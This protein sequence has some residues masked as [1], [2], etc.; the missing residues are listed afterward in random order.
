MKRIILI[1]SFILVFVFCMAGF[2][3]ESRIQE[4][5]RTAQTMEQSTEENIETEQ[6]DS[7]AGNAE[8]EQT[9]YIG[10]VPEEYFS[11]ADHAGQVIEVTYDSRDYTDDSQPAI[12]KTAYV[13]L[14]Y[15]YDEA[16]QDTRYDILY[17]MHGWT[18]TAGDFFNES[19]SGIVPM[20]DHMIENGEIPPLIVVCATFDAQN[21]SQ[22]FSRSVEELSVF[23]NDLRENLM[24]YIESHYHTYAEDVTPQAFQ[25]SRAHRAFGGFSLGA[26]TTWYH[27]IYNL[28]YI[29][30][31]LPM[32]GDCWI[33]GTYGGRYYP[34]ETVDYLENM[35][36]EG[37][38]GESDFRIYQ[39]IGTKVACKPEI[40][41]RR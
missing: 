37:G 21:H 14:P 25:A 7:M 35:L 24:P 15:G 1:F 30:Y 23:H 33:M 27:F 26:V 31:F 29:Q 28:D 4:T 39:G 3:Q 6:S 2:S 17:L 32:S 36:A 34:V 5:E 13:Y 20:L 11:A 16:D 40:S 9:E 22:S 19:G 8:Q 12:Q 18:M 10:A 38:Y 41:K